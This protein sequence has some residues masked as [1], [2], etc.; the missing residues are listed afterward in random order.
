MVSP[1]S[2]SWNQFY[3]YLRI[4]QIRIFVE[5]VD[6]KKSRFKQRMNLSYSRQKTRQYFH[7]LS[8]IQATVATAA[9]PCAVPM[10]DNLHTCFAVNTSIQ[11][12]NKPTCHNYCKKIM[13]FSLFLTI[14]GS[15]R[16]QIRER[17]YGL[18]N[19]NRVWTFSR[20]H[21][22]EFESSQ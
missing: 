22:S 7:R 17:M 13:S 5:T 6:K 18:E 15:I 2:S 21:E 9:F 16:I 3:S 4:R 1:P 10:L 8:D 19:P 12:A 20:I 11:L 14:F